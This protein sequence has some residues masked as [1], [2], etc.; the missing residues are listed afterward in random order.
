MRKIL[1]AFAQDKPKKKCWGNF[2]IEGN[3][4]VYSTS[5]KKEYH[6]NKDDL[7]KDYPKNLHKKLLSN[8]AM[9][10]FRYSGTFNDVIAEFNKGY[11]IYLSWQEDVSNIIA[12]KLDNKKIVGNSATLPL[13]GQY[14][15]YGNPNPNRKQTTIQRLM[16]DNGTILIPFNAM[17]QANLDLNKLE[18]LDQGAEEDVKIK[19]IVNNNSTKYK[20]VTKY[21][22][23]HFTGASLLKCES[24]YF[25]FD[26]DR[27]ELKH[28]IFNPFIVE[29]PG[30]VESIQ[31]AYDLLMPQKVK[32]AIKKGLKVERQ[33]EWFFIPAKVVAP[34]V[35]K[36][37][38]LL[39]MAMDDKYSSEFSML[40][41][42]VTKK[43][44]AAMQAKAKK[45]SEKL[46]RK[47]ALSNGVNRPNN[48]DLCFQKDGK[49]YVSGLIHHQGR[50]HR[51]LTLTGWYEVCA[52]TATKSFTVTGDID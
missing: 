34:K 46:P 16:R 24:K 3:Q 30:K 7:S 18:F 35:V 31:A 21:E 47:Q 48:A 2:R 9:F 32:D 25:L 29:L 5:E 40:K 36:E 45:I 52:N 1:A 11:T 17:T 50:E 14:S 20:D 26:I 13:I 38:L 6:Y 39:I 37:D 42:L 49:T 43:Q 22:Q 8:P 51:D 27:A 4:L 41:T 15:S 28:H 33:G 44:L 10:T 12:I 23:R 19:V